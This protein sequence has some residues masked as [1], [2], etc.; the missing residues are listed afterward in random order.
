MLVTTDWLAAHLRDTD[1]VLLHVGDDSAY[2]ARHIPGARLIRMMDVGTM[3]HQDPNARMLEMPSAD[4]IRSALESF[5]ISDHSRIVV[6]FGT[7]W[8]SPATR[9]LFTLEYAGLG[10]N[11]SLLDGGMPAWE[12]DGHPTTDAMPAVRR[13]HLSPL[14]TRPLVITAAF[15]QSHV[16][17]PGWVLV[18]GRAEGFYDGVLEGGPRAARRKGHIPGAKSVPFTSVTTD[19]LHLK[20]PAELAELFRAA[21]VAPGDTVMG[22]CHVGQ[23]ATAMLFAAKSLGHPVRL[24]DGSFEDWAL[25]DLPVETSRRAVG[26]P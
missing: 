2:K 23:Q 24:Y 16:G 25:R 5:G 15:V 14:T 4:S 6:Y 19:D 12:R 8:V 20:S 11:A 13:G 9:I 3:N 10:A 18:D 26:A 22:Y 1:L 17:Q 7:D 21:G